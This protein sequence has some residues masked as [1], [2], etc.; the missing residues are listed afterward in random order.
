MGRGADHP[1]GG[2]PDLIREALARSP[3]G[4]WR[5]CRPTPGD[6]R[7]NPGVLAAEVTPGAMLERDHAER[8]SGFRS[9]CYFEWNHRGAVEEVRQ[10]ER[11]VRAFGIDPGSRRTGWGVVDVAGSRMIF[12][13]A[14]V[15]ELDERRPLAERLS[16]LHRGLSE[17]VSCHRPDCVFLESAFHHKN[18]RSALVLGHA[19]GVALL[20]ASQASET[21]GEVAPAEVKKAVTGSGRADKSQVQAM[22]RVILGLPSTP[23][24]DAADA[25]AVAIAGATRRRWD[26][27]KSGGSPVVSRRRTV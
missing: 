22:I 13:Q 23:A 20:V 2:P 15:I 27:A 5:W 18:A 7:P 8:L 1:G 4:R 24:E 26:A 19:R 12:V 9:A 10:V 25:L 16:A 14:G 3:D 6:P 11:T 17:V 21:L